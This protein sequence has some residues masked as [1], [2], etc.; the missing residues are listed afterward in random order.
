MVYVESGALPYDIFIA[1]NHCT[2][3]WNHGANEKNGIR[4]QYS[5]TSSWSIG[6]KKIGA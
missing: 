3:Q 5:E 1:K 6:E 2:M 4:V